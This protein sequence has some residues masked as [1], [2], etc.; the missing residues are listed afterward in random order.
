MIS[1]WF[2]LILRYAYTCAYI[3]SHSLFFLFLLKRALQMKRDIELR[4]PVAHTSIRL[5]KME[6]DKK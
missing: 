3:F 6:S 1:E 5:G 2:L 4:N